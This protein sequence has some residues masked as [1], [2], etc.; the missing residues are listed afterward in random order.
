MTCQ[1]NLT[2][3]LY[4]TTWPDKMNWQHELTKCAVN[5]IWAKTTWTDNIR[6]NNL[7]WHGIKYFFS[8]FISCYI[9][10][11]CCLRSDHVNSKFCQFML[12]VHFVRQSCPVKLSGKV[13]L[14]YCHFKLLVRI[15]SGHVMGMRSGHVVRSYCQV[16]L[17]GHNVRSSCCQC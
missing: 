11:S 16:I 4:W 14:S 17:Y 3:Q 6:S 15:L 12:S 8:H 1:H 2:W 9:V 13:M 7:T 5:M 10:R